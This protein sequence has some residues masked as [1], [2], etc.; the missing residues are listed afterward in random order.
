METK[1]PSLQSTILKD[2]WK[3]RRKIAWISFL[4]CLLYPFVVMTVHR[5]V[6]AEVAETML[7]F[8]T[9]MYSLAGANLVAYFAFSSWENVRG[10]PQ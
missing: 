10:V 2:G 9:P 4:Y 6:G 3:N 7:E 8:A 5:S 1:E